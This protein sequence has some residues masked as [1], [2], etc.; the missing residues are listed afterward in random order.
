FY[1]GTKRTVK[2]ADSEEIGDSS[3]SKVYYKATNRKKNVV[4]GCGKGKNSLKPTAI[5]KRKVEPQLDQQGYESVFFIKTE[6]LISQ[7]KKNNDELR[8]LFSG[9][10][11]INTVKESIKFEKPV[12][13]NIPDFSE[14]KFQDRFNFKEGKLPFICRKNC[15][16]LFNNAMNSLNE[17]NNSR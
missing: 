16:D 8:E 1:M 14:N 2:Q 12:L 15:I 7:T 10:N 4:E 11:L 5:K 13:I 6:G 3:S 17:D 9:N